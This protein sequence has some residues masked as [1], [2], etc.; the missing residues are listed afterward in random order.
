M[1]SVPGEL[2]RLVGDDA[3]RAAL[4]PAEAA[5]DVRREQC[6]HLQELAVVH[7]V[8]DHGVHVVGLVRRV[9]HECVQLAVLVGD[10]QLGVNVVVR[11]R[12]LEVVARQVGQQRL[13]VVDGVG[14]VGREVVRV[15]GLRVVGAG[16]AEVLLRHVL[17][18]DGLDDVRAGDEHERLLVDHHGEVGDRRGVDGSAGARAHDHR[19]LRDD[20]AGHH[21]AVEDVA[22][23]AERHHALLDPGAARVVDADHRAADLQREVH[24]LDDLL[25]EHL[26][27]GP[28]EH[29]EVLGEDADLA[30][31]DGAVA[32][33]HAVAVRPGLVQPERGGPVPGQLVHL[34]ERALVEQRVDPLASGHLALGVLLLH[35]PR[36]AGVHRLVV[37][38]VQVGELAG[39]GVD[40]DVLRNLGPAGQA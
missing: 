20:A 16:A 7:H 27:E 29:G 19:D 10:V 33:D 30:S 3:D 17:A 18:G 21:V 35:C 14:L 2:H 5:D 23:E 24:H 15:A 12:V 39:R 25:A 13:D 37:A 31:V 28:A 11:R 22:V 32:G 38:P 6:L 26:A 36:G 34:D 4:D 40:V 8:V 9:G 1:S